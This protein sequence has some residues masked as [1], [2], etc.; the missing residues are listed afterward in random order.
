M[1]RFRSIRL[2]SST[3]NSTFASA[4]LRDELLEHLS[5]MAPNLEEI[6]LDG[7]S[8]ALGSP[9]YWDTFFSSCLKLR[10]LGLRN[11]NE[12]TPALARELDELSI[13]K[14]HQ[15][16]NFTQLCWPKAPQPQVVDIVASAIQQLFDPQYFR[17]VEPQ[18]FVPALHAWVVREWG[19]PLTRLRVSGEPLCARLIREIPISLLTIAVKELYSTGLP[20]NLP[21][22][23][24][25]GFLRDVAVLFRNNSRDPGFVVDLSEWAA[26]EAAK[27]VSSSWDDQLM[28]MVT[29][30][31]F[32]G[33]AGFKV[34]EKTLTDAIVHLCPS[35]PMENLLWAERQ[36]SRFARL[37]STLVS[38]IV[39]D[40]SLMRAFQCDLLDTFEAA[41][42]SFCTVDAVLR[43]IVDAI[44]SPESSPAQCL[45]CLF[46]ALP[47]MIDR[48]LMLDQYM[49]DQLYDSSFKALTKQIGSC[50]VAERRSCLPLKPSVWRYLAESRLLAHLPGLI[51]DDWWEDSSFFDFLLRTHDEKFWTAVLRERLV[52][53]YSEDFGRRMYHLVVKGHPKV[54]Q[55]LF[56]GIGCGGQWFGQWS[57]ILALPEFLESSNAFKAFHVRPDPMGLKL[58]AW[59]GGWQEQN[60]AMLCSNL[61]ERFKEEPRQ[62]SVITG[63]CYL[64]ARAALMGQSSQP[65]RAAFDVLMISGDKSKAEPFDPNTEQALN[66]FV[67]AAFDAVSQLSEKDGVLAFIFRSLVHRGSAE[68]LQ[69]C[70]ATDPDLLTR[71][72]RN[73]G[74]GW[75]FISFLRVQNYSLVSTLLL[76]WSKK[77]ERLPSRAISAMLECRP[78]VYHCFNGIAVGIVRAFLQ[79]VASQTSLLPE[80][81]STPLS[82]PLVEISPN[83]TLRSHLL[84]HPKSLPEIFNI[85]TTLAQWEALP[86]AWLSLV[87]LPLHPSSRQRYLENFNM[88]KNLDAAVMKVLMRVSSSLLSPFASFL[89]LP[90]TPREQH[91]R[92]LSVFKEFVRTHLDL[93]AARDN[94]DGLLGNA[95]SLR[96][97]VS[98]LK[99]PVSADVLNTAAMIACFKLGNVANAKKYAQLLEFGP[100]MHFPY[101]DAELL[102]KR[103]RPAPEVPA[104]TSSNASSGSKKK[105][106]QKVSSRVAASSSSSATSVSP[107]SPASPVASTSPPTVSQASSSSTAHAQP[108]QASSGGIEFKK[109]QGKLFS[110]SSPTL[111]V[112]PTVTLRASAAPTPYKSPGAA[113]VFLSC[114]VC[115]DGLPDFGLLPCGH[116]L[117]SECSDPL[118]DGECPLCRRKVDYRSKMFFSQGDS[119]D[120]PN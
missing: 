53:L 7:T 52:P 71:L 89:A 45:R 106:K 65:L 56:V 92:C 20:D 86:S 24:R 104:A 84:S 75:Q 13:G 5:D 69:R 98:S 114:P 97:T 88:Y 112:S 118:R 58:E 95:L 23:Q 31:D 105:G 26:S 57:Q 119:S 93:L 82:D 54:D 3:R 91:L 101:L 103:L 29:A 73:L 70:I 63:V 32:G 9:R 100:Q 12:Q 49:R 36:V 61:L 120:E 48:N 64:L 19:L 76:D 4:A 25:L 14:S 109:S 15:G 113:L 55:L 111:N 110:S 37:P 74:K 1:A 27:H 60:I 77:D 16:L 94:W 44:P 21:Y 102:W 66:Y 30:F 8:W 18:N 80:F 99:L 40:I 79:E 68:L 117:C 59:L 43:A 17:L 33:A 96:K 38:Q 67:S 62:N 10:R 42:S 6:S 72:P 39:A 108:K 115:M 2:Q 22:V 51:G 85:P 87:H 28:M 90:N 107:D 83:I 78:F 35:K 116:M 41:S 47:Q 50:S 46:L 11:T 81:L 34:G